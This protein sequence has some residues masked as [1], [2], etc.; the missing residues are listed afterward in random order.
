MRCVICSTEF[1]PRSIRFKACGDACRAEL[2]R[3]NKLHDNN[4]PSKDTENQIIR[5]NNK[6]LLRG[7]HAS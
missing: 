2:K 7:N 4:H 6:F 1:K 5:F 3:R